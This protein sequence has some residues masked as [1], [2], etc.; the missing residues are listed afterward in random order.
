MHIYPARGPMPP[1]PMPQVI[2]NR[3]K[4]PAATFATLGRRT[5]F[6]RRRGF[7]RRPFER[8]VFFTRRGFFRARGTAM[9]S[10]PFLRARGTV[11]MTFWMGKDTFFLR[12]RGSFFSG[13]SFRSNIFSGFGT[14]FFLNRPR[15]TGDLLVRWWIVEELDPTSLMPSV[16]P[17]V[18]DVTIV[19]PMHSTFWKGCM[20]VH[21]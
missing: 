20:R 13:P 16:G 14:I 2:G 8:R 1:P 11:L 15:S 10:R 7:L 19:M 12:A 3:S 5:G 17:V 9:G 6:L 21:E 18:A 4:H